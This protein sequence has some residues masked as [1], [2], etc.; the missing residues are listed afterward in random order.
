MKTP[1]RE[2][3]RPPPSWSI[4][5]SWCYGGSI[6][7]GVQDDILVQ[8]TRDSEQSLQH[9]HRQWSPWGG[10]E[11]GRRGFPGEVVQDPENF[12][13]CRLGFGAQICSALGLF[14]AFC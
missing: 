12:P 4:Q 9:Q 3:V 2:A 5:G 7:S 14:A 13:G 6:P 8:V 10:A 1:R 11:S